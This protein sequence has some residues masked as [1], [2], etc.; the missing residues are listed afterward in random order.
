VSVPHEM[1]FKRVVEKFKGSGDVSNPKPMK[2]D[3]SKVPT[4][5]V[6]AIEAYFLQQP[7]AHLRDAVRDLGFCLGKTHSIDVF[8]SQFKIFM[9]SII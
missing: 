7:E 9:L 5:D 2:T 8:I 4:H 6:E 1:A 3:E